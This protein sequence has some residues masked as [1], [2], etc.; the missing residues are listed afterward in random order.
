[1]VK[2]SVANLQKKSWSRRW[3]HAK[4]YSNRRST[5][6]RQIYGNFRRQ[7]EGICLWIGGQIWWGFCDHGERFLKQIQ[8]PQNHAFITIWLLNMP[9]FFIKLPH[10]L[11]WAINA[12][13]RIMIMINS[14]LISCA[15]LRGCPHITSA[16]AGGGGAGVICGK[17]QMLT[18]A[19][20]GGRGGKPNADH[21]WRDGVESEFFLII[22]L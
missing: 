11:Q 13:I 18:I 5:H 3:I 14:I 12:C 16:A 21:C 10:K 6:S 7:I 17:W 22:W 20:E 9:F 4:W 2:K 8:Q 15:L 19:D 1:M